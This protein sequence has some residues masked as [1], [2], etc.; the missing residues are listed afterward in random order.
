M[1]DEFRVAADRRDDNRARGS[2]CFQQGDAHTFRTRRKG[3]DIKPGQQLG[4]VGA[5][6]KKLDA[7]PGFAFQFFA[8]RAVTDKN[9]FRVRNRGDGA[10]QQRIIFFRHEP[11]HG[12][13]SSTGGLTRPGKTL[14]TNAIGNES[15]PVRQ[16]TFLFARLTADFLRNRNGQLLK[17]SEYVVVFFPTLAGNALA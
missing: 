16:N 10:Q 4:D 9:K 13:D 11:S 1:L 8:D 5:L 17:L 12:A 2:H 6:A 3:K 15:E 14:N 7:R